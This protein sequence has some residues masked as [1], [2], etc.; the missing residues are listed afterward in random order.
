MC[1]KEGMQHIYLDNKK[2]MKQM[3]PELEWE[4]QYICEGC[5]KREAGNRQ[6]MKIKRKI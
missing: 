4:E 1:G 2:T 5:A 6:W 3:C